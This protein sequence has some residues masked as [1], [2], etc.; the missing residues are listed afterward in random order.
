MVEPCGCS[1]FEGMFDDVWNRDYTE[2]DL[3]FLCTYAECGCSNDFSEK[4]ASKPIG[5]SK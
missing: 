2:E 1:H 3:R 4:R 5:D